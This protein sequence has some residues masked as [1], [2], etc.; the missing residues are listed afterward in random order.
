[1]NK[2]TDNKH[3]HFSEFP[4]IK[5]GIQWAKQTILPGFDGVPLYHALLFVY[6]EAMK[7]DIMMRAKG[8]AFSFFLAI[9]PGIIFLLTLIPYLPFTEYYVEIWKSSLTGL[10]PTQAE[11]YIFGMMDSLGKTTRVS[12]QILSLILMLYFTSNGVSSMLVSFSKSYKSTYKSRNYFQHKLRA[13]EI[14]FLLFLLM[15]LSTGLVILGNIWLE[16]LFNKLDLS[17][18][19]RITIDI[20]RWIIVIVLFYSIF[21]ML[22][23]FGPAM[24]KKIKFFSPGAGVAT[25]LAI[26]TSIGFSYYVNNFSSYNEIYGS[27]GAIIITMIWIQINSMA[28]IVGYELNASIAVNRDMRFKV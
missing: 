26:V 27:L 28:L 13:L 25:F 15:I 9:F 22:Y 23:R 3:L 5:K 11:A 18:F 8:M 17:S 4:F 24:K 19:Y 12:S 7:D 20:L 16:I 10:L 1:L 6:N 14:T 21:S 2:L